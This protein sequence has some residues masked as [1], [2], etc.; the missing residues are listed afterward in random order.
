M[1]AAPE[2]VI[3]SFDFGHAASFKDGRF[4]IDDW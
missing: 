4:S 2:P 1:A 3:V